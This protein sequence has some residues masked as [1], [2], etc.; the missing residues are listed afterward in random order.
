[1]LSWMGP[2][3][4]ILLL[5]RFQEGVMKM[6]QRALSILLS[7]VMVLTFIPSI[8]FAYPGDEG[9]S[10]EREITRI[11]FTHQ[12][13]YKIE[14]YVTNGYWDENENWIE[15]PEPYLQFDEPWF[16]EGDYILV[17]YEGETD[18]LK[19]T[20]VNILDEE[21]DEIIT[22]AAENDDNDIIYPFTEWVKEQTYD[23]PFTAD[24]E[25]EHLYR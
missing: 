9:E 18:P 3:G 5:E 13:D 21:G 10:A 24:T 16:E 7:L 12:G 25:E 23:N 4:P 8:A 6:S 22:F 19:Y 11:E 14:G 17:W 15:T 1:M 20:A 2:G